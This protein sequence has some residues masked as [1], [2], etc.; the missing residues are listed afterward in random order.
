MHIEF[1][2]EEQSA[3]QTLRSLVPNIVG[4]DVSFAIHSYQGKFN[5]LQKV[6]VRL[7]GYAN[8]LPADWKIVILIDRDNEDC[9]ALK[10]QL[11][12]IAFEAGLSTKST[13]GKNK[14]F[15]VL[16]R[17]AIEEL[18]AWFF[19]DIEAINAAYPRVSAHLAQQSPYRIPDAIK[20]GTWEAL[21]RELHQAGY[22]QGSRIPKITVARNIAIHM[23]PERN[24]SQSFQ[25][26]RLGLLT[27]LDL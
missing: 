6:P 27:I 14:N 18:E 24:I 5:L 20:G 7:R 4:S 25:V 22:Y 10:A 23:Q 12:Q 17:L 3:E 13:T 8:W 16:N 9:Y 26:F 2:V 15:Q 21:E 19:G 1:L 11:E